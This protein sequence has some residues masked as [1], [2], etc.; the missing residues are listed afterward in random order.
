MRE[1]A[2]QDEQIFLVGAQ[3]QL[4]LNVYCAKDSEQRLPRPS[5]DLLRRTLSERIIQAFWWRATFSGPFKWKSLKLVSI[6]VPEQICI[7]HGPT[8]SENVHLRELLTSA[9]GSTSVIITNPPDRH[10]TA[11]PPCRTNPKKTSY[12]AITNKDM[13]LSF[14][15]LELHQ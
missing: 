2:H 9:T 1:R 13:F 12:S 10:L 5:H 6:S 15:T 8:M 3:G 4:C 11:S 7:C 14:E